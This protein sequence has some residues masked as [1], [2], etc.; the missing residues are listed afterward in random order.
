ML[1]MTEKDKNFI[2]KNFENATV[3]LEATDVNDVLDAISDG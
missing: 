3:L 1:N 2:R